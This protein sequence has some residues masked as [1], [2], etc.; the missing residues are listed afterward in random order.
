MDSGSSGH[1]LTNGSPQ[2]NIQ[3][4]H[5]PLRIK[6]PDGNTLVSNNKCELKIYPQLSKEAR[7]AYTFNDIT[8]PLISVAKLCDSDCMVIFVKQRA[9]IIKE[10]KIIGEAPRDKITKLWTTKLNHENLN[11]CN[12]KQQKRPNDECHSP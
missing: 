6:Q 1:F 10:G 7:K 2:T 11:E 5:L 8:F 4:Q 12:D 9:Y 3:R